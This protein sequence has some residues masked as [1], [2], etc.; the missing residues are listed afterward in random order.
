[1]AIVR[2]ATTTA[3]AAG[4]ASPAKRGRGRAKGGPDGPGRTAEPAG[5]G[6]APSLPGSDPDTGDEPS[7][8]DEPGAGKT[9]VPAAERRRAAMILV[10]LWR[11]L[12]RDL[13]IVVLGDE[14]QVR[15][16]G[17]LD[18]LRRTAEWLGPGGASLGAFLGRLDVAGELLEA[19]VRPELVLDTLLMHWPAATPR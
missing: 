19:N 7:E 18:D 2:V 4:P 3:G 8:L 12:A 9:A 5:G 14:R 1:M 15:D 16:P 6:A 13:L 10:G 11:D 17:L